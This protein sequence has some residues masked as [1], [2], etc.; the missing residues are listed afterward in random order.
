M[1][2][3]ARMQVWFENQI[4]RFMWSVNKYMYVVFVVLGCFFSDSTSFLAF[5]IEM[6][7]QIVGVI[8]VV[9]EMEEDTATMDSE[10]GSVT[11]SRK[12]RGS[13]KKT[14]APLKIKI[15]KKKHKRRGSDVCFMTFHC[16]TVLNLMAV[17]FD[18]V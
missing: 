17:V 10:D 3:R 15:N 12:E 11:G 18:F 13:A 7:V 1:A 2:Q 9:V 8:S 4:A 5:T 6:L 16:F 14:V